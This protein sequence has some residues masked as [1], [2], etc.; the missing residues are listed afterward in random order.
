[1][2]NELNQ[3]KREESAMTTQ[4]Y[5]DNELRIAIRDEERVVKS[6]LA[7]RQAGLCDFIEMATQFPNELAHRVQWM[8][9]GNYGKGQQLM[10]ER[11]TTRM[12]RAAQFVQMVAVFE[13]GT[14]RDMARKSWRKFPDESKKLLDSAVNAVIEQWNESRKEG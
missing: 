3:T 1:M 14:T 2:H 4:E 13:F 9:E 11:A 5:E 12:N 8:L 6:S 10:C 7:D